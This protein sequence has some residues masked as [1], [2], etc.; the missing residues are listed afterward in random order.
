[1]SFLKKLGDLFGSQSHSVAN[2]YWVYARC[3]RCGEVL[4]G[5]IDLRN[6]LSVEYG[7]TEAQTSYVCRKLLSGNGSNLC[8]QNIEIRLEFDSSRKLIDQQ[9]SGGTL[10]DEAAYAAQES[11]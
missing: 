4:R 5:R 10:V 6:D 7:E 11:S 9:A 1:M 8:F 2:V 3:N